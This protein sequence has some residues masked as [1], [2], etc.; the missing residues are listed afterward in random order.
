MS[1]MRDG[2]LLALQ[3]FTIIPYKKEVPFRDK[4]VKWLVRF[5]PF[6]GIVSGTLATCQY[7]LLTQLTSVSSLFLALW[8]LFFYVAF[9]GGIHLDGWMDCSDAYF[10]YRDQKKRV[11]IMS[12][13]RVGAFAVLSVFF[14]LLFRFLFIYETVESSTFHV[15]YLVM[16]PFISRLGMGSL[17]ITAP[18]AKQTGMAYEFKKELSNDDLRFYL[19]SYGL[20]ITLCVFMIPN[21]VSFILLMVAFALAFHIVAKRFFQKNFGGITGDTLGAYV[22]GKETFLWAVLWLLL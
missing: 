14:L 22:E 10:S 9:S 13:P 20:L 16:I 21:Q 15:L 19:V 8:L 2:F 17:L 12:D 18:L 3:F 1:N 6:I 4:R 11:E 7:L 5:L